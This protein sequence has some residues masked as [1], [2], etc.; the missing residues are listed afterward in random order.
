MRAEGQQTGTGT[1]SKETDQ[2]A[3][4]MSSAQAAVRVFVLWKKILE[5]LQP[6]L[7]ER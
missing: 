1:C 4:K 3:Q 2:A 6:L 7:S 5:E